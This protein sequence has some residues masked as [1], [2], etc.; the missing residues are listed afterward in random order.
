MSGSMVAHDCEVWIEARV[1]LRITS[2]F[3]HGSAINDRHYDVCQPHSGTNPSSTLDGKLP[4]VGEGMR[5]SSETE[6]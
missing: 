6:P 4:N 5:Q 2:N 1:G 3:C